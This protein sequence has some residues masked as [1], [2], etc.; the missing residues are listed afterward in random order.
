M[1]VCSLVPH[2]CIYCIVLTMM[3]IALG[4][5]KIII[6]GGQDGTAEP[7]QSYMSGNQM[8]AILDTKTWQW[9]SP[10]ASSYQPFPRSF[11]VAS[12]VNNTK[13]VYGLGMCNILCT[14]YISDVL[15]VSGRAELSYG[16]RWILCI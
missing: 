7:F 1:Q 14:L 3:C 16:V 4:E 8:T 6:T 15:I 9:S 13:M 5:D 10:P 12:L 2:S 11:A